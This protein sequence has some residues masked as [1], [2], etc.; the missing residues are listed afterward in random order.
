[1]EEHRNYNVGESNY[2]K[3]KYQVWDIWKD[4][5][6]NPWEADIVK[7]ILRKKD[8]EENDFEKIRH[9]LTEM[10]EQTEKEY[11]RLDG[12]IEKIK[13]EY[14]LSESQISWISKLLL[15][16]CEDYLY[17]LYNLERS[18]FDIKGR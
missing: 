13:T 10:I 9:I 6:L 16:K 15:F 3:H 1:M 4:F 14:N 8:G 12:L 7:R 18:I 5:D 17:R 11:F 2:S